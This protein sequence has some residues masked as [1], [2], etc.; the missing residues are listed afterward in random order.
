LT[1]EERREM[2]EHLEQDFVRFPKPKV[3]GVIKESVDGEIH[4]RRAIEKEVQGW[5]DR[6]WAINEYV[7]KYFKPKPICSE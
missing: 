6:S 4:P 3:R 2:I 1:D 7:D 5:I